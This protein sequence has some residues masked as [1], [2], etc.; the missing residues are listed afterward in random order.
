M[1]AVAQPNIEI[2]APVSSLNDVYCVLRKHYG[3]EW[4]ARDDIGGLMELFDI[5]PLMERHA[6]MSYRSDEPDFEDGI[7]RAVAEDNDADVI[8]TC[9]V[10]AFHHSSVR[11]MDAEQCRALLLA[12]SKA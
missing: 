5:R 4:A 2:M 1:E 11:S 6:R 9:D 8:V 7:I 12:D 3:E 10:E